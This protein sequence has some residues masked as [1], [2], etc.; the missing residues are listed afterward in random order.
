MFDQWGS[1]ISFVRV[2]I[3]YSVVFDLG[4]CKP[5]KLNGKDRRQKNWIFSVCASLVIAYY[6]HH[7]NAPAIFSHNELLC[8]DMCSV[9]GGGGGG[10]GCNLWGGGAQTEKT[11]K[12]Y[13]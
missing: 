9:P 8:N 7:S 4:P 1:L 3:L 13:F 5:M 10:M 6:L 11:R 12:I 2:D